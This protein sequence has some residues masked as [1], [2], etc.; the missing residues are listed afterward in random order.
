M[1]IFNY[2]FMIKSF[3]VGGLISITVPLIGSIVVSKKTSTIGDALSHTSLAGVAIGLIVGINPII[4]SILICLLAAF[5]IEFLRK[6][7]PKSSDI[8]IAIVMSFGIGLAAILS[9]FIPGA[10]NLESFLFG[11]IAAVSNFE[12]ILVLIISILV[13]LIYIKMY[14]GLLYIVFDEKGAELAGVPVKRINF[15]FTILT[16]L[17]IAIGS[18]IVGVLM[19]SSLM[20]L[21]VATAIRVAKSF[22]QSIKIS[23]VL[24]FIY[25]IA[26]IIMSFY[27]KLKPGG[28][29][30][31]IGVIVLVIELI[32]ESI[33]KKQV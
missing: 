3:I 21:P 30:V 11:S 32:Y 1:V 28:T 14:Y 17:T 33:S 24:S 9:D 23:L 8:V 15:I 27:F 25:V 18:R 20:V 12:V 4:G 2:D 22:S 7:F 16:A 13:I 5:S 26:G 10:N 31:I 19:I 29:I 6:K